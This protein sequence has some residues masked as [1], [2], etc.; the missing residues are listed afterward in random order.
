MMSCE[1]LSLMTLLLVIYLVL[2]RDVRRINVNPP[3]PDG[4]RPNPPP[5]PPSIKS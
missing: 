5:P 4:P 1:S 3:P 2:R